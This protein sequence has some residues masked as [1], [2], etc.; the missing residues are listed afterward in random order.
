V[1][2]LL[3]FVLP[4]SPVFSVAGLPRLGFALLFLLGSLL[5]VTAVVTPHK[6]IVFAGRTNVV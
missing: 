5:D 2:T 1:A 4:L 3:P 6:S